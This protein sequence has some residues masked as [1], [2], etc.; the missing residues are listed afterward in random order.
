MV[1]PC[2]YYFKLRYIQ[3]KSAI[4]FAIKYLDYHISFPIQ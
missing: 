4:L 1:S 3:I 2:L